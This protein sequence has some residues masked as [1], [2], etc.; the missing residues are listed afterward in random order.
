MPLANDVEVITPTRQFLGPQGQV[1]TDANGNIL[2]ILL[3]RENTLAILQS[4]T[5]AG[6]ATNPI[7]LALATDTLAV[8]LLPGASSTNPNAYIAPWASVTQITIDASGATGGAS[9]A[10]TGTTTYTVTPSATRHLLTLTGTPQATL[11]LTVA[12][13][14]ASPVLVGIEI[15]V[16]LANSLGAISSYTLTSAGGGKTYNLPTNIAAGGRGLRLVWNGSLWLPVRYVT[17]EQ[18]ILSAY[19]VGYSAGGG[20]AVGD[21]SIAIGPSAVAFSNGAFAI[22]PFSTAYASNSAAING[23]AYGNS[24][25]GIGGK[26]GNFLS[27]I[28][29][30]ALVPLTATTGTL[31]VNPASLVGLIDLNNTLILQYGSDT[32][33]CVAGTAVATVSGI[34]GATFDIP[35]TFSAEPGFP[36]AWPT[37]VA[38]WNTAGNNITLFNGTQGQA[39]LALGISKVPCVN[40]GEQL[41]SNRGQLSYANTARNSAV[42]PFVIGLNGAVLTTDAN[43]VPGSSPRWIPPAGAYM[44]KVRAIGRLQNSTT[45]I[46]TIERTFT[47]AS[48]GAT[49][50]VAPV[51]SALAAT[52]VADT[53]GLTGFSLAIAASAVVTTAVDVT[54]GKTLAG[55]AFYEVLIEYVACQ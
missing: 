31:T 6:T 38:G 19:G 39:S 1:K 41:Q 21:Q 37:T 45:A 49:A 9:G 29:G 52:G 53:T 23:T 27:G 22:G 11:A 40:Y 33:V 18:N 7:E 12:S 17:V 36:S 34:T 20:F 10:G 51:V 32:F 2:A 5:G 25:V 46:S 3:P 24:S 43:T 35:V 16:L 55:N 13:P 30:M 47:V 15:E 54:I 28:V 44:C 4:T 48:T 26:A 14:G 50:G 42:T 8:A